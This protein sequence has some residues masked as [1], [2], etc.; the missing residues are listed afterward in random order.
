[1]SDRTDIAGTNQWS[2]NY[3]NIHNLALPQASSASS[4]T[5][6]TTYKYWR[7]RA[8]SAFLGACGTITKAYFWKLG[9]YRNATLAAADTY[10]LSSNNYL[11][12]YAN[13]LGI[14]TNGT[15]PTTQ[16]GTKRDSMFVSK[17]DWTQQWGSTTQFA[18]V[19]GTTAL[20]NNA[21]D[22]IFNAEF[23]CIQFT[24]D[25]VGE[26]GAI[27]FPDNM[28]FDA[29]VRGGTFIL[30]AATAAASTTW[31]PMVAKSASQPTK[32]LG[33]EGIF[34]AVPSTGVIAAGNQALDTNFKVFTV[35]AADLVYSWP[36][37]ST[38]SVGGGGNL[39]NSIR[40]QGLTVIIDGGTS[41]N[42]ALDFNVHCVP[43]ADAAP[44]LGS[45]TKFN[46]IVTNY[47]F[48]SPNWTLTFEY[49]PSF[50][51]SC[52]FVVYVRS[53]EGTGALGTSASPVLGVLTSTT[54]TV[55]DPP[56]YGT[57]VI[58]IVIGSWVKADTIPNTGSIGGVASFLQA[59]G[60]PLGYATLNDYRTETIFGK[61]AIHFYADVTQ[62]QG[63]GPS[64]GDNHSG[65]SLPR[66]N[67]QTVSF[68]F[69]IPYRTVAAW[70]FAGST[71]WMDGG[72]DGSGIRRSG[73]Y[74]GVAPPNS[75]FTNLQT[76]YLNGGPAISTFGGLRAST[77]DTTTSW[78]HLTF[79]FNS[80]QD[81]PRLRVFSD[82]RPMSGIDCFIGRLTVWDFAITKTQNDQNY[83]AGF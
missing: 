24:L 55:V 39:V 45:S 36:T 76:Y 47:A 73:F 2:W 37:L 68:W 20:Q 70:G 34:N 25:V 44:V 54:V 15:T 18:S 9:L 52:K 31:I 43:A 19:N 49:T 27:R 46:C 51:G 16:T 17:G 78:Q 82:C 13:V 40:R 63:G 7:I 74:H 10:G 69:H 12:Q 41:A 29:N 23:A 56:I 57:P 42:T 5:A 4:V 21:V 33:R 67:V 79:V 28:Y 3:L 60:Y 30:E 1:M 38:L 81:T 22:V 71:W 80:S 62:G 59:T 83:A 6:P 72:D 11:Q 77:M 58:D 66:A 8:S 64:N 26:I 65:I 53:G 35:A 61:K 14:S 75:I 48:V 32:F 50:S